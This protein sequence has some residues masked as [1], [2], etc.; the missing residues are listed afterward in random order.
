MPYVTIHLPLL[1]L[2][3]VSLLSVSVDALGNREVPGLR[4]PEED[5]ESRLIREE[6]R[7]RG[8]HAREK[9]LLGEMASLERDM[10]DKKA[11]VAQLRRGIERL[12]QEARE[13]E[14]K[15][16]E[17]ELSNAS[18]EARIGKKLAVMYKY[19]RRGHLA[20]IASAEDL[21]QLSR[22]IKYA[23]S[24]FLEDAR[25][26]DVL[27]AKKVS[28]VGEIT[29]IREELAGRGTTIDEERGRLTLL[30]KELDAGVLMLMQIHRE[31]E[32]Y[33]TAVREQ[34]LATKNIGNALEDV[35]VADFRSAGPGSEFGS[36]KGRLPL[37]MEGKLVSGN[38][39]VKSREMNLHKGVFI[40]SSGDRDVAAVF[41]GRV[42]YS[43]ILKGYGEMVIIHHGARFFTISAY[44]SERSVQTGDQVDTG[45]VIGEAGRGASDGIHL[46]YFEIRKAE[47][48]LDPFEWLKGS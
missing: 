47:R 6:E 36:F 43:G 46:V 18:A 35:K 19:A 27:V 44:L 42:E 32:F 10:A 22:R 15:L 11:F 5:R 1:I 39:L 20:V 33:E 14:R 38:K 21:H 28:L 29:G 3:L 25:D 16:A 8:L 48:I 40:E 2:S 12:E 24:V 37:P 30:Q 26:L 7:L 41:P 31:K 34:Q 9:D 13:K 17:L 45:Q 4:P 23:R